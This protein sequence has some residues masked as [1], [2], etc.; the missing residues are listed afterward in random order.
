MIRTRDF[1]LGVIAIIF[2]VSSIGLTALLNIPNSLTGNFEVIKF[3]ESNESELSVIV[4]PESNDRA[5]NI[6]RLKEKIS[7]GEGL[8]AAGSVVLTSVSTPEVKG[9][10]E[11]EDEMVARAVK[12]CTAPTDYSKIVSSW[13]VQGLLQKYAEGAR[14][15]YVESTA[16]TSA[17][18]STVVTE[19]ES[20]LL[21]LLTSNSRNAYDT[22]I[23]GN[24]IGVTTTGAL[25]YNSDAVSFKQTSTA[26][27]VGYALDGFPIY[28]LLDDDS[29]LDSCGGLKV[30][31]GYQ[32]HLRA[33]ENFVVGCYAGT[34]EKFSSES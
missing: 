15:Y 20:V 27:L 24:V 32:Y 23:D 16:V 4:F 21:Q 9:E 29:V 1:L 28:G 19:E 12:T 8:S 34:P 7:N 18:S 11:K 14:V 10:D 3:T 31:T 26:T 33:S 2:L 30:A 22:C 17:G 25:L 6:A 5:D 13:P